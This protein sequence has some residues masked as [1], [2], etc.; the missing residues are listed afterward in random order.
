MELVDHDTNFAEGDEY[1]DEGDLV[2]FDEDEDL[3]E[4]DDPAGAAAAFFAAHHRR[5]GKNK[6]S[7]K[8]F[9]ELPG[10][11]PQELT[12]AVHKLLEAPATLSEP[13]RKLFVPEYNEWLALLHAGFSLLLHGVG[14]KKEL[15]EDFVAGFNGPETPVVVL[16]GYSSGARVRD[17]LLTLLTQV[18]RVTQP[19]AGSTR[20]LCKQLRQAFAAA[21]PPAISSPVGVEQMVLKLM[22]TP[23]VSKPHA[24][25]HHPSAGGVERIRSGA[26]APPAAA[27]AAVAS[28]PPPARDERD[29][30]DESAASASASVGA[31][32]LVAENEDVEEM[33]AEEVAAAARS[34]SLLTPSGQGATKRQRRMEERLHP[35]SSRKHAVNASPSASAACGVGGGEACGGEAV[36]LTNTSGCASSASAARPSPPAAEDGASPTVDE[37]VGDPSPM[38]GSA[39]PAYRLRARPCQA[40]EAGEDSFDNMGGGHGGRGMAAVPAAGT[41]RAPAHVYVVI[42]AIDGAALRTEESQA[43]LAEIARIPQIHLIASCSHRHTA[44]MWDARKARALNWAWREAATMSSYTVEATDTIHEL[45]GC[46]YESAVGTEGKS[47]QVVLSHLTPNAQKLFNFLIGYQ[48]DNPRTAGLSFAD[49]YQKARGLFLATSETSLKKHINEFTTHD[50]V[51]TRSGPGGVQ[52]YYCHF[53]RETLQAL[54]AQASA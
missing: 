13:I 20:A 6:Y 44:V 21:A 33:A 30:R 53:P 46:L 43:L 52:V 26:P 49:L 24:Q 36:I 32:D 16:Q 22:P 15:I 12:E 2:N 10:G 37:S 40:E 41:V 31:F 47:A 50:L 11:E 38:P 3:E 18:V 17:L 48:L 34:E 9:A 35:R 1:D 14:S 29:G 4:E 39:P 23:P 51:R 28:A 5:A 42:H 54:Q 27:A 45:L 8:P 7:R 19:P 25:Q